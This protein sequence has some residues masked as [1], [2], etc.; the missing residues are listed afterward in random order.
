MTSPSLDVSGRCRG[1]G[2]RIYDAVASEVR[3]N[4]EKTTV[5]WYYEYNMSSILVLSQWIFRERATDRRRVP[6]RGQQHQRLLR[7]RRGALQAGVRDDRVGA[8]RGGETR[9]RPLRLLRDCVQAV[10]SGGVQCQEDKGLG[11]L[12]LLG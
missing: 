5:K 4:K 7:H 3:S 2:T 9:E 1:R 6:R 10:L 12:T 11:H 8:E